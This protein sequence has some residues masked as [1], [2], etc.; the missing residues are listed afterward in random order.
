MIEAR[1]STLVISGHLVPDPVIRL[2]IENCQLEASNSVI[3]MALAYLLK[4]RPVAR[5]WRLPSLDTHDKVYI[6][7]TH[8]R[9]KA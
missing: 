2:A 4:G 7:K 9:A 3:C 8:K 6:A 5:S 1:D